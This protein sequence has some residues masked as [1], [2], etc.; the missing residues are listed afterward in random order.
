M[1]DPNAQPPFHVQTWPLTKTNIET[2]KL[3]KGLASTSPLASDRLQDLENFWDSILNVVNGVLQTNHAYP[4]YTALTL[5]SA[6][7]HQRSLNT[8]DSSSS[9]SFGLLSR[10]LPI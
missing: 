2:H 9:T 6:S 10:P 4:V 7:T 5:V 1:P 8:T 3:T